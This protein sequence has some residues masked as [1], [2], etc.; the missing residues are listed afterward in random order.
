[1]FG[2]NGS[3]FSPYRTQPELA[4]GRL[5]GLGHRL[6]PARELIV[7]PGPAD[8]VQDRQEFGEHVGQGLLA[9]HDSVPLNPLAVVRVLRLH[10]LEVGGALGEL[11][12][13]FGEL[14][15]DGLVSGRGVPWDMPPLLAVLGRFVLALLLL[16]G[17]AYLSCHRVDAPPVADDRPRIGVVRRRHQAAPESRLS[18]PSSTISASTT[19]SSPAPGASRPLSLSLAE[20]PLSCALCCD[21]A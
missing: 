15:R 19:S 2:S 6:E 9:D 3:P 18:L 1:M 21:W 4:D 7:L 13:E 5:D 10:A 16:R 8:V 14:R 17:L 11:R 20:A 12:G